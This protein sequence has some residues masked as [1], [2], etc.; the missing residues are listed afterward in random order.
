M[1]VSYSP[2]YTIEQ[3]GQIAMPF[4]LIIFQLVLKYEIKLL[5]KQLSYQLKVVIDRYINLKYI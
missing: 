3:S 2:T 5:L 4:S 1:M